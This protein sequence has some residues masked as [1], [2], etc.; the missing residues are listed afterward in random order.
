MA[1]KLPNELWQRIFIFASASNDNK[2]LLW[3]DG[4]RVSKQLF[5]TT[6]DCGITRIPDFE[7]SIKTY[8]L[9]YQKRK[10]NA[11]RKAIL[12]Y[13]GADKDAREEGG[14][15]DVPHWGL[16]LYDRPASLEK[17]TKGPED[18]GQND[19]GNECR[20]IND[21]ELPD[22]TFDSEKHEISFNWIE[23]SSKLFA[24]EA[25]MSKR[26]RV[27]EQSLKDTA[28]SLESSTRP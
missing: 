24:E 13:L 5:S 1:H 16:E 7:T 17:Q 6:I 2:P 14:T 23:V 28:R 11:W 15:F 18:E 26:N 9:I 3:L 22:F 10:R 12:F 20:I 25:E 4:R 21:T 19:N 27:S 8:M